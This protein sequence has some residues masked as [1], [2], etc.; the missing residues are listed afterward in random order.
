[1][2]N[3]NILAP[4]SSKSYNF[5]KKISLEVI[6]GMSRMVAILFMLKNISILMCVLLFINFPQLLH[7]GNVHKPGTNPFCVSLP[8]TD[9]AHSYNHH[10]DLQHH[11]PAPTRDVVS[12]Q[13]YPSLM[14]VCDLI[15]ILTPP[16]LGKRFKA[17]L[18]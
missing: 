12:H 9:N 5:E 18:S 13:L 2:F 11:Y 17:N 1:M 14:A 6:I 3:F 10:H 4:P 16:L 8:R 7:S 15:P